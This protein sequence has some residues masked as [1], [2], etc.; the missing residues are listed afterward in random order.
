MKPLLLCFIVSIPFLSSG[1]TQYN[2]QPYS[3]TYP[4]PSNLI[5]KRQIQM[6]KDVKSLTLKG[7]PLKHAK[8]IYQQRLEQL[9]DRGKEGEFLLDQILEPYCQRVLQHILDSN[10]D[11]PAQDIKLLI[12][13]S[14]VPNAS[15]LGEGTIVLNLGLL[16]RLRSEEELAFTLCHELAH[17]VKDHVNQN[18]VSRIDKFYS[19]ET[20]ERLKEI[21]RSE[22]NQNAQAIDLLREFTYNS[23]RHSRYKESE[24]DSIAL[25]LMSQTH[26]DLSGATQL[27]SVLQEV[28]QNKYAFGVDM[29]DYFQDL[30]HPLKE[31]LFQYVPD[32]TFFY[33]DQSDYDWEKDSLRTHPQT[34]KRKEDLAR[35]LSSSQFRNKQSIRS[36]TAA[37][38]TLTQMCDFEI[39]CYDYSR[40]HYG[41]A[42]YQSLLLLE[43]YPENI[44][45]HAM[46]GLCLNGLY[47]A[48]EKH[49][50]NAALSLPNRQYAE[51]YNLFLHFFNSLRMRDFRELSFLYLEPYQEHCL[52][53]EFCGFAYIEM[54][55]INPKAGSALELK[56]QYLQAFPKGAYRKE[57]LRLFD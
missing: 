21:Q 4:F 28:D 27:L 47:K 43:L 51:N 41:D 26:Y 44:F 52:K 49:R 12:S 31:E 9:D 35:Q 25:V 39:I 34:E 8:E 20:Q 48:K 2:Y 5:E 23:N 16:S 30:G 17:Y 46:V 50:L 57:V 15:C 1:Q 42:L 56:G 6:R 54:A 55:T 32:T 38:R 37:F 13:R 33:S 7:K 19:K 14:S 22:F 3:L 40:K 29:R 24:A 18:I 45:L 10:P 53:D 36:D 11:I